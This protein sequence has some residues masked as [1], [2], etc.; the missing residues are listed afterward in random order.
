MAKILGK[1]ISRLSKNFGKIIRKTQILAKE[2]RA[3]ATILGK[4]I[5]SQLW[6]TYVLSG[7]SKRKR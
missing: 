2:R 4:I 6:A 5:S 1:I 3:L 7:I